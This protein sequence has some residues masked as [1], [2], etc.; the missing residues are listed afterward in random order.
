MSPQA[1]NEGVPLME[2]IVG[3]AA[4][5]PSPQLA[6]RCGH[7]G[8][9]SVDGPHGTGRHHAGTSVE[10]ETPNGV[11][12]CNPIDQLIEVD[13]PADDPD[14]V[15]LLQAGEARRAGGPRVAAGTEE[16]ADLTVW[17]AVCGG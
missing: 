14:A 17:V 10:R 7:L 6:R 13:L 8:M 5:D 16:S 9:G 1:S 4:G 15:L 2:G 11:W 3:K 12:R